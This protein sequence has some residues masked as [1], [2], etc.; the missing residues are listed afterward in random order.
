MSQ[1]IEPIINR[2]IH[3]AIFT[4]SLP[5]MISSVLETLYQLI[6]AYW[7]GKIGANALA[8]IGGSSFILWAVFSL[9]ALSVNGIAT[10]VAQHIGAGRAQ[11]GRLAA[12]QGMLL[13]TLSAL[14]LAVLVFVSQN[15]LYR[16]MGFDP[17]VTVL[18]R[19]YMNIILLGLVFSFG[20]TGIE[21]VFRGLGDTR[22]PMIVLAVAL[23]FNAVLDPFLIF[24]WWVFPALGIAGAAWATIFSEAL[25]LFILTLILARKHYLPKIKLNSALFRSETVQQILAIGAPVAFGGFFFSLIYVFLTRI[26]S[27]F[28]MEAVA[29]IGIGHRIE[30]IAWFACVGFSVAASTLVGQN[31]GANRWKQ[32]ERSVWLVSGY[33]VGLLL[34]ISAV[35]YFA[36]QTLMGIFTNNPVVQNIGRD[37][38][39]II[40]L[41]EIFLGLEVIMEGAFSGA[42][43]TLPVMLVSVPVTAA[44]IPLAWLFAI[45]WQ[46]GIDG[47]WWAIA[48]TTGI[49]GFLNTLLFALG[50]WKKKRLTP[51]A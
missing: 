31:V 24:G 41:F 1:N 16:V 9:T 17:Q 45:H 22:T 6:D 51:G 23:M 26:I 47:I 10:L 14:L 44:R 43:Y 38:L 28:G 11:Q 29:A 25:G 15:A 19:A 33:G 48:M 37:Y 49:K 27:R 12:G 42:G 32:A 2:N 4:L 36:P 5:G 30:G 20:F 35:Y 7:I 18:A 8:A 46:W 34:I 40:A 3:R 50:I 13:N 21:G 39:K